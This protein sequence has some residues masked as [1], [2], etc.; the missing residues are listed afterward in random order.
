LVSGGAFGKGQVYK[1]G[2]VTG[3]TSLTQLSIGL[4]LGGKAY[5]EMIFFQDERAFKDFTSGNFEFGANASAI[6]ITASAQAQAG[7]EGE[8]ASANSEQA[9][10]NYT[11]G[12]AVFV[13]GKGG[14][15]YEA[16][17]SGQK[18]SYKANP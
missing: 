7:T 10:N 2:N 11:K 18:F 6:A 1:K 3:S 5:S 13:R 12:M 14:L 4:Q 16:S 9:K 17:I 8:T 15:M